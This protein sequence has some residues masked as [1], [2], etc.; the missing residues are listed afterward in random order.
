MYVVLQRAFISSSYPLGAGLLLSGAD[1]SPNV[2]S[3]LRRRGL[4]DD[5][6]DTERRDPGQL[7]SDGAGH[8][9]RE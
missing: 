4:P 3:V 9:A 8:I 6:D 7:R 5:P 1:L 2:G